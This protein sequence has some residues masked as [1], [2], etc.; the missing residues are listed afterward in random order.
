MILDL[1]AAPDEVR[2]DL[3]AS[4]MPAGAVGRQTA[5]DKETCTAIS[6]GSLG[7]GG[8]GRSRHAQKL[9][10]GGGFGA[11]PG[12]RAPIRNRATRIV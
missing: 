3:I 10:R 9:H 1:F 12:A 2:G 6:R 8:G 4:C 11:R 5:G 7:A